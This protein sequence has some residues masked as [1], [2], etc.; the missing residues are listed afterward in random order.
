MV[1]SPSSTLSSLCRLQPSSDAIRDRYN[2]FDRVGVVSKAGDMFVEIGRRELKP[3][4]QEK[5]VGA[6]PSLHVALIARI[7]LQGTEPKSK[8]KRSTVHR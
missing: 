7:G 3:E 1:E 6:G 2:S 5:M 4:E 8:H